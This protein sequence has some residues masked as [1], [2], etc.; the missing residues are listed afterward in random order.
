MYRPGN[1]PSNPADLPGYVTQELASISRAWVSAEDVILL[2]E[3]HKEPIRLPQDAVAL[4]IADGVDWN[5]GAGAG[6]Y[7]Y[8]GGAW[9][10]V[11]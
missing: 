11:G 8:Q 7:R 5:P 3:L 9:T 6:L 10:K 1:N 2:K 4:C